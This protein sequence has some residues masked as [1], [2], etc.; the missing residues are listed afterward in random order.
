MT[1][2]LLQYIWQFQYFN[3]STLT[4]SD[5]ESLEIIHPGTFNTNQGPDFL[6]A[7][8]KIKNTVW[9][10]NIE[11]H[12]NTSDWD[13]HHHTGDDNYKNIVLHVVWNNDQALPQP[14]PVVALHDK[15]SKLLLKKYDE[16]MKADTFIAC[17]KSI[18]LIEPIVWSIWKERLLVERLQQ[19]SAM[20]LQYAAQRNFH[21]EE[22]FWW[23][24][25][26]NFGVKINAEAFEQMARSIPIN[27]LA[28]NKDQIHRIEALLFGQA[29]LLKTEFNESYPTMLKKEYNFL[30]KK[31]KLAPSNVPLHF[32]RMRPS[33]FPTV[34]LAQLAMLIHK[35]KHLF[36][37]VKE[38]GS[39]KQVA[40]LLD[41]TANDYWHYHYLFD[42]VSSYK[43]KK[44]GTQMM[45]NILIN[46]IVPILF[47]YGHYHNE[48]VYKDKAL[49][50]LEQIA[51]EKNSITAGY[52]ALGV[53]N[54]N[55]FDSQAL[56][57][58]K[59]E[60]CNKKKCLECTI[61]NKLLK[62]V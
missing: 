37:F 31:Y 45:N 49:L 55:A 35:S 26:K 53:S 6:N 59:N 54:K 33:N 13:K 44:L 20:I 2:R 16:L 46:T 60:Y 30:A 47:T 22:I 43:E 24:I 17:E 51:T 1:E 19:R 28:K 36:S 18:H 11:L 50:W 4:T 32:L 56:I 10:G 52:M 7:K 42:E 34:R 12:I 25:A 29:G 15:V 39:Y 27:I 58:L 9:A 14:F 40:A 48:S 61:G 8:I 57:Q 38:M 5:D 41:V 21:W 23:L 3:K 62:I